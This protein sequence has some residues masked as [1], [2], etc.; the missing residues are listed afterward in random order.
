[1]ERIADLFN[2]RATGHFST[3]F[4]DDKACVDYPVSPKGKLYS[5]DSFAVYNQKREE[6]HARMEEG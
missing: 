3:L 4:H 5:F 6:I 1:V 2:T